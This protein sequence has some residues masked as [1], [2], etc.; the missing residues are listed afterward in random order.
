MLIPNG[1][2]TGQ[3]PWYQRAEEPLTTERIGTWREDLTP[4]EASLVEWLVGPHMNTFGYRTVSNPPASWHI[5]RDLA[6]TVLSAARRRAGEFPALWYSFVRSRQ[7]RKE[8]IAKER[9][10]NR[11]L[12]RCADF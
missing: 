9:F 2:P 1:D 3:Q 4:N 8:E 12:T 5:V 10:R 11:N 7:L 6:S